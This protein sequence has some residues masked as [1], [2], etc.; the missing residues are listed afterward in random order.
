[1]KNLIPILIE[2]AKIAADI[3]T[4]VA[5]GNTLA[6][7]H[8]AKDYLNLSAKQYAI[9][10]ALKDKTAPKPN[11]IKPNPAFGY[12][13]GGENTLRNSYMEREQLRA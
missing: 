5:E 9:V 8:L 7:Y 1:M 2:M 11:Y 4:A 3:D 12:G 6:A 10:S 13:Y